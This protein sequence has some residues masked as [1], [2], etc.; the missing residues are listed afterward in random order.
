MTDRNLASRNVDES[1]G[2]RGAGAGIGFGEVHVPARSVATLSG[3]ALTAALTLPTVAAAMPSRDQTRPLSSTSS[4]PDR[5]LEGQPLPPPAGHTLVATFYVGTGTQNYECIANPDGT[6][7]WRSRPAALLVPDLTSGIVFGLHDTRSP[8]GQP[9]VPQWTL[10]SDGSRVVGRVA[11]DGTFPAPDPSKAIPALRLDVIENSGLGRL[12]S[13]DVIQRD[14]VSGGVGPTG[15]CD[16]ASSTPVASP[17][18]ARYTFWAP[19]E[20]TGTSRD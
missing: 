19:D 15:S 8:Q 10:T 14:L 9:P 12:A 6:A 4:A 3:L 11:A 18:H 1:P 2:A 5:A 7:T 16:P 17:Y 13:V 20:E